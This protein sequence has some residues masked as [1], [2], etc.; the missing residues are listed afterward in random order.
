MNR[1]RNF[2][3]IFIFVVILLI[4]VVVLEYGRGLMNSSGTAYSRKFLESDVE[5]RYVLIMP[6]AET[7]T[8]SVRVS[9]S[10][11]SDDAVFYSTDVS[12]IENYLVSKSVNVEVKDVPSENVLINGIIPIIVGI[13]VM[14]FYLVNRLMSTGPKDFVYCSCSSLFFFFPFFLKVDS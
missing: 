4:A 10:D 2:N 13:I 6:N 7:P 11:G 14:V 1:T 9:F 8:G 3:S 5:V 12:S